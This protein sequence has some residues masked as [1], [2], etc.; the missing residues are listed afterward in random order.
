MRTTS[1]LTTAL[2]PSYPNTPD[3][4]PILEFLNLLNCRSSTTHDLAL[5]SILK[6]LLDAMKG[7]KPSDLKSLLPK[8]YPYRNL[9][10]SLTKAFLASLLRLQPSNS[11]PSKI[12]DLLPS[13][14]TLFPAAPR[15]L[16]QECYLRTPS[17][18]EGECGGVGGG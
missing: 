10:P 8:M 15:Q 5:R 1:S 17:A 3:T 2:S 7:A 14:G 9:T 16:K 6:S 18:F 11:V 12:W 13:D 4:T